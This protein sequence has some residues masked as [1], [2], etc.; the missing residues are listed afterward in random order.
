[1]NL[2]FA[3]IAQ[4]AVSSVLLRKASV[5]DARR[6]SFAAGHRRRVVEAGGARFAS[7]L[8]FVSSSRTGAAVTTV[9]SCEPRLANAVGNA[10]AARW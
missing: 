9:G 1:M 4:G 8:V 5:A 7:I 3:G 2:V 10:R 6:D